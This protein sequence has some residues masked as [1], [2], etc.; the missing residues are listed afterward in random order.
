VELA[1]DLQA[2]TK[3]KALLGSQRHEVEHI[4]ALL[5][6]EVPEFYASL[7]DGTPTQL[8]LRLLILTAARSQPIGF[9]GWKKSAMSFGPFPLGK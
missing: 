4:P 2:V 6:S 3:A 7:S 8:A 9:A 1:V 5:W